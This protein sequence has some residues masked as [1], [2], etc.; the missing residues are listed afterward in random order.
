MCGCSSRRRLTR[1]PVSEDVTADENIGRAVRIRWI[2][3]GLHSDR[4]WAGLHE[5]ELDMK[6][7]E[8][9]TVGL[10][11]GENENVVAVAQTHDAA[12]GNWM[13]VQVVWKVAVIAIDFL[14]EAKVMQLQVVK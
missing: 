1:C 5:W 9:D 4:S 14:E 11:I 6:A 12:N 3:S 13:A 10:W 2:D 7:A 8:C